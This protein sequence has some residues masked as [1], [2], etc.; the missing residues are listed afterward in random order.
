MDRFEGATEEQEILNA[1]QLRNLSKLFKK[2]YI[3]CSLLRLKGF[4]D[5]EILSKLL[6]GCNKASLS[7]KAKPSNGGGGGEGFLARV[8][9]G[10]V[11]KVAIDRAAAAV[12]AQTSSSLPSV[13]SRMRKRLSTSGGYLSRPA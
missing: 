13:S 6:D 5:E 4:S 12:Q 7:S 2:V 9:G 3:A 11:A 8:V 1:E 10:V